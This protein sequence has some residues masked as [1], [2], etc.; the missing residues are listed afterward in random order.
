MRE[1]LAAAERRLEAAG[2]ETPELDARVLLGHVSGRND[3]GLLAHD[4]D[5][6]GPFEEAFEALLRRREGGE[7]VAYLTG[8]KEFFSLSFEVGPDVLVP[9]P[10]T[11]L[12]VEEGVAFVVARGE[13]CRV[14]DVGTGSG[15]IAVSLAYELSSC[16]GPAGCSTIVA[17]D[18]SGEALAVAR[19]NAERLLPVATNVEPALSFTRGD[20]SRGL[21]ADSVDLVVSNPPYLTPDELRGARRE[22]G[23]EPR[24]ALDG[25]SGDGLGVVRE[26]I[27]DSGRVLRA[28]GRLLC[29]IGAGQGI[30]ATEIAQG[31]GFVEVRV[32]RDLAGR[33]RVLRA[34][35][36]TH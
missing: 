14:V 13:N 2:S 21:A 6:L 27:A 4:R 33:P 10:E 7:P 35:A 34:D 26:L 28:G 17:V 32:L 29:E 8:H 11:E 9:R 19:R 12:L 15:A 20:L 25:G 30:R 24:M 31:L 3:A 16:G 22:L 5:P 23:F 36:A 18:R 1:A